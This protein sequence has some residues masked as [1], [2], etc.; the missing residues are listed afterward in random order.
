M[1]I[2]GVHQLREDVEMVGV[3]GDQFH[4]VDREICQTWT[5]KKK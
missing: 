5:L 1:G 4:M 2:D 3:H